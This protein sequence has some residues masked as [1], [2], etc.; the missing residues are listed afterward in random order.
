L[1]IFS[2]R[3]LVFPRLEVRAYPA[4]RSSFF[5]RKKRRKIPVIT[6]NFGR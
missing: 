3:G 6:E 2:R 4:A 5:H 1:N